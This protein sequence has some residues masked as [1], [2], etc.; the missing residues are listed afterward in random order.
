AR[1]AV[2]GAAHDARCG[3]LSALGREDPRAGKPMS[4]IDDDIERRL[5]NWGLWR[6]GGLD[7]AQAN[8][9]DETFDGYGTGSRGYRE[10]RMPVLAGEAIDTDRAI[11]RLAEDL[12]EALRAQ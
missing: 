4:A 11:H 7:Y 12:Q 3:R 10:T 6:G 2:A 9:S 1:H 8:A 5:L